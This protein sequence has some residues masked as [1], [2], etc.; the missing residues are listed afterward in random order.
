MISRGNVVKEERVNN[1]TKLMLR[2]Y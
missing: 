2:R 1:M